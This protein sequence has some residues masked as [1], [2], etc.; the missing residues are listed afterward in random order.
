M[1]STF[2][3]QEKDFQRSLFFFPSRKA[4][5]NGREREIK[6]NKCIC[7]KSNGTN[8]GWQYFTERL[9]SYGPKFML[10]KFENFSVF[11]LFALWI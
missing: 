4:W 1:K 8:S 10:D 9:G 3:A 6:K 7:R 11:F 5:E 2:S